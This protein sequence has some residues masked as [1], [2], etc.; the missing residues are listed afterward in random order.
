MLI[1]NRYNVIKTLAQN[2]MG[3]TQLAL[4]INTNKKIIRSKEG[5]WV[6]SNG[7]LQLAET[8]YQE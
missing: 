6:V 5:Y 8:T 4:D 7:L 3:L 2:S 1:D